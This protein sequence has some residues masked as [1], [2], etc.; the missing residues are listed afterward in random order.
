MGQPMPLLILME[1]VGVGAVVGLSG[2]GVEV[3]FVG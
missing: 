2:A 1:G 3:V